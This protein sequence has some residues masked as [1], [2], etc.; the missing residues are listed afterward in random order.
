MSFAARCCVSKR[1][2]RSAQ[3]QPLIEKILS[4][5]AEEAGMAATVRARLTRSVF[6]S[7]ISSSAITRYYASGILYVKFLDSDCWFV[8]PGRKN[9]LELTVRKIWVLVLQILQLLL[10]CSGSGSAGVSSNY[11]TSLRI[12]QSARSGMKSSGSYFG[13]FLEE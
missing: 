11:P 9:W 4:E 12:L 8:L 3:C 13:K 10:G 5:A 7:P 1:S 6:E 2:F